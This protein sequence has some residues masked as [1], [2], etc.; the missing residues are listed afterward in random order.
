MIRFCCTLCGEKISVQDQ[1]SG[2][3]IKCPKC[4]GICVVPNKSPQ[5]K[6]HCESCGQSIRVP[7]VHTGKKGRCPKCK[8]IVVVPSLKAGMVDGS[9]TV[10]IV[11]PMCNETMQAPEGSKEQFIECPGCSSYM[12]APSGSVKARLAEPGLSIPAG[13]DDG[14]Y[15]DESDLPEEG[16]GVDRRLIL[17]ISG[18]AAVVVVGLIILVTVILSSGSG[19]VEEPDVSPRQEVADVDSQ[20]NPVASDTQPTE[21]FTLQP[22]KEDIA[23]KEPAHSLAAVSDAARSS[24]LKLRLQP[25]RKHRL[26][27]I[28]E[29]KV[30]LTTMGQRQDI[31]NIST[32]DLEFDVE[33]VDAN[34]V[35]RIRVTYLALREKGGSAAGQ[36]EYDSTKPDTGAANP[37]APTYSAMMGKSFVMKVTPYGKMLELQGIDEMYL[38]MAEKIVEDEDESIRKRAIERA[39]E[40]AEKRA[41]RYIEMLNQKY[42]SRKKREEA[43]SDLIKK[44]PFFAAEKIRGTVGNVIMSFPGGPVETGDSWQ[45]GAVLPAA[46]PVDIDLTY[47]LKEK[48]QGVALIDINSKIDLVD[49]PASNPDSP[50]GPTKASLTGSYEGSLQIDSKTGWM[51]HKKATMRCSGQM[52]MSPNEQMQQAMTMPVSMETVTTVE[53][54]E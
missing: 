4:S 15:E 32:V 45:G 40:G 33:Q 34:G 16:A 14:S 13:A 3:R 30:S 36:M 53:P 27:I 26:R 51:I 43:V 24:D 19:P 48:K 9:E 17:A 22:P 49:E 7:Q 38:R 5:I 8:N 23:L 10:T 50:L 47:T 2:K 54:I 6:F 42:G 29:D 1:L 35:A 18:V 46:A 41:E 39:A 21:S 28:R 25:G 37:F 52:K 31:H 11:C 20:S 44:N 12:E